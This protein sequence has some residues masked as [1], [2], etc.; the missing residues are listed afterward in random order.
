MSKNRLKISIFLCLEMG[1]YRFELPFIILYKDHSMD[2]YL[3][4]L[5]PSKLLL[6]Q[7]ISSLFFVHWANK[8]PYFNNGQYQHTIYKPKTTWE[9][10][11]QLCNQTT[12]SPQCSYRA[13]KCGYDIFW[14][15]QLNSP[16][17]LFLTKFTISP[18]VRWDHGKDMIDRTAFWTLSWCWTGSDM[19]IV[20]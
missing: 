16:H 14:Y 17:F 4:S 19:N 10:L 11:P 12:K 15:V 3:V 8:T 20:D 9:N 5:H 18:I 2:I 13:Y 1:F 6:K 7:T